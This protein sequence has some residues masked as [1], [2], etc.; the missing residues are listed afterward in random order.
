M[1]YAAGTT[2]TSAVV[3]DRRVDNAPVKGYD[4]QAENR[5]GGSAGKIEAGDVLVLTWS[6]QMNITTLLSGWSG[7]GSA[8][9]T[10]RLA[11]GAVSGV[12]TGSSADALQ[13]LTAAGSVSGLGNVNLNGNDDQVEED[14]H[15]RGH[16]H[17]EHGDDRWHGSHGRAHHA[18]DRHERQRQ[19][20]NLERH[21]DHDLDAERH[22]PATPWATPARPR[23]SASWESRIVTSSRLE[24]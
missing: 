1:T 22:W 21:A 5:T 8:N 23:R 11:D 19:R 10:V 7:S 13:L 24:R 14:H 3:T 18:R 20:P 9:M 16:G 2:V 12:G 15:V 4:V 6:R 17:P